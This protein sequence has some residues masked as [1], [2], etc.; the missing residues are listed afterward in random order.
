M[1]TLKV[2]DVYPM[3]YESFE[4]AAAHLTH[5]IEEV[6]NSRRLHSAVGYLSRCSSRSNTPGARS[7][8]PLDPVRPQGPT[9]GGGQK[10]FRMATPT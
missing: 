2:E 10:S 4:E 8:L 1:K 3:A 7:K 9:P 5:F 6:Y